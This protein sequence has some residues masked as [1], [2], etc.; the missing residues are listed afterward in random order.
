M[1]YAAFLSYSHEDTRAAVQ[2]HRALERY[3]VPRGLVGTAGCAGPVPR[4]LGTVFRDRDELPTS[5]DLSS[6]VV[7]ALRSSRHLIVV[8]SRHS[9]DSPWVNEEI[10]RFRRIHGQERVHA[11]VIDGEPNAA[12]RG[13]PSSECYPAAL[14]DTSQPD[15]QQ[16]NAADARP[17]KDGRTRARLKL[18]A[19]LL[20]LDFDA[21]RRREAKRRRVRIATATAVA[22]VVGSIVLTL[23]LGLFRESRRADEAEQVGRRMN[24]IAD[25]LKKKWVRAGLVPTPLIDA[26]LIDDTVAV[27]RLLRAGATL[28]EPWGPERLTPLMI[29]CQ[30]GHPS[31]TALLLDR[32][33]ATDELDH[34][35]LGP[36]HHAAAA[37]HVEL[38]D[39][40]VKAGVDPDQ[41]GPRGKGAFQGARPI[42]LAAMEGQIGV[43][44]RLLELGVPIEVSGEAPEFT[45]SPLYACA[46]ANQAE[47]AKFLLRAGARRDVRDILERTPYEAACELGNGQVATVLAP[48]DRNRAD[49]LGR[50][51]V[52]AIVQVFV[53][54]NPEKIDE[55]LAAGANVNCVD[56]KTGQTPLSQTLTMATAL[57]GSHLRPGTPFDETHKQ[58]S[59]RIIRALLEK[60]ADPN[61]PAIR[62]MLHLVIV[63]DQ[64]ELL[65]PLVDA[66]LDLEARDESGRTLA[67]SAAMFNAKKCLAVFRADGGRSRSKQETSKASNGRDG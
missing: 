6:A 38:V 61:V 57:S 56:P 55:L 60:N 30:V 28:N 59:L 33:A 19:G 66:G 50:Q 34:Q 58:W 10:V 51:L 32:G 35:G 16:P 14:R 11:Y 45:D 4:R 17:G 20:G 65:K 53:Q 40:L 44:R 13:D 41:S 7:D 24:A 64:S 37:G 31:V 27:D 23:S 21:L 22:A 12:D 29:A 52:S 36:L 62:R 48:P 49:D 25:N 67:E 26:V 1:K 42:D 47:A 8:C 43:I 15:G 46:S 18:L 5:H 3:R 2:L 39:M 63:S 9:A 54:R